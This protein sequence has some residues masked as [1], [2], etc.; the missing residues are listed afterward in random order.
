ML[1]T[2]P[3]GHNRKENEHLKSSEKGPRD[4][5]NRGVLQQPRIELCSFQGEDPRAWLRKCNKFFVV[6]QV[7]DSH[8]LYYVEMLLDG[9]ADI[10]FQSFKLVKE[11]ISWDDFCESLTK[12][13][14]KKGGLDEQEEFNK[15]VQGGSVLEYVEKF[16][17]LKSVLLCRNPQLDGKYFISS[18]ISR[19]EIHS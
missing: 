9:K 19:L 14:G 4:R 5:A 11:K 13:F 12:R 16:E 8:K 7:S 3:G 10:W 1:P 2:P 6:N 18:F 17:E 15:L